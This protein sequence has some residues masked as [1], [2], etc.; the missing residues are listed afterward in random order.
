MGSLSSD[1]ALKRKRD[2]IIA[3]DKSNTKSIDLF[4]ARNKLYYEEGRGIISFSIAF[5]ELKSKSREELSEE[6]KKHDWYFELF[7]RLTGDI[8][9]PNN[10]EAINENKIKF[11]T[12]NYDRSL[13]QFLFESLF[14]S[15]S[16]RRDIIQDLVLNFDITHV[17][18]KLAMLN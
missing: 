10:L 17:Y 18:G 7:D 13:D 1:R 12:Y 5:H 6:E 15:F 11:L 8:S 3:F 16:S 2:L 4:L 9:D 14:Y